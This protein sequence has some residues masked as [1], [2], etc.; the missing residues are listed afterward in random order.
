MVRQ[1]EISF[2]FLTRVLLHVDKQASIDTFLYIIYFRIR[3][4]IRSFAIFVHTKQRTL[5][6]F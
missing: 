5:T 6:P 3:F 2:Y 1:R 4:E